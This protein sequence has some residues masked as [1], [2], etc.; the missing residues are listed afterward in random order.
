MKIGNPSKFL[1]DLTKQFL[2]GRVRRFGSRPRFPR[3]F[4]TIEKPTSLLP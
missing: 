4:I 3:G 2:R 1:R